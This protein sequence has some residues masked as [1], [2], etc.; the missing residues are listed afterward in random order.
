MKSN[1]LDLFFSLGNK[2][3]KGDPK[4]KADFDYYLYWMMFLAFVTVGIG[5]FMTFLKT[6]GI[7]Y[8]G[9]TCVMIAILWF[10]Y[11]GL[12]QMYHFRKML[13]TDLKKEMNIESKDDMMKGFELDDETKETFDNELKGGRDANE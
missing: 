11:N 5:Y 3:T 10:Q 9:W 7:Q 13:K 4:R 6:M 8:L 12:V 2:V 1:P